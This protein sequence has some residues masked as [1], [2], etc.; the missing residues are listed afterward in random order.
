MIMYNGRA[1]FLISVRFASSGM[2]HRCIPPMESRVRHRYGHLNSGRVRRPVVMPR[3]P[4]QIT[5]I[6]IPSASPTL[7]PQHDG[8]RPRA[9][10]IAI[11]HLSGCVRP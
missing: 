4:E 2:G 10:S 3:L 8:A 11:G 6:T 1:N 5:E 7:R 9:G